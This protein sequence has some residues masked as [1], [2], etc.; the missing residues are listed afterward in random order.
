MKELSL[1]YT[2]MFVLL[3]YG[4]AVIDQLAVNVPISDVSLSKQLIYQLRN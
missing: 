4:A 1:A 2:Q 3:Y